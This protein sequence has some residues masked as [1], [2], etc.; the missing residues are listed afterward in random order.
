MSKRKFNCA[1]CNIRNVETNHPTQK[2]CG[3]SRCKNVYA[4]LYKTG[5]FKSYVRKDKIINSKP[6]FKLLKAIFFIAEHIIFGL[7]VKSNKDLWAT[8][9]FAIILYSYLREIYGGRK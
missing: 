4:K 6:K 9:L 7:L 2:T 5:Y 1:I 3:M 8:I